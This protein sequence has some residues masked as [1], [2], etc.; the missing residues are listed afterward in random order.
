MFEYVDT[1]TTS[2][3]MIAFYIGSV[4][5][6]ILWVFYS[7][8]WTG[9]A[10]EAYIITMCVFVL[11]PYDFRQKDLKKRWYWKSMLIGG[12]LIHPLFLGGLWFL[13]SRFP[14]FVGGSGTI[15]LMAILL[16]PLEG[17]ILASIVKRFSPSGP[18]QSDASPTPSD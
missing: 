14:I 7:C 8:L 4:P 13:D 12:A 2:P 3:V 6:G 16:G 10:L 18:I 11:Q 17:I 1:K 9:F 15:F 5:F